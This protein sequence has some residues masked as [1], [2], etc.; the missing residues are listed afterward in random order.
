MKLAKQ[1][2]GDVIELEKNAAAK[3]WKLGHKAEVREDKIYEFQ[4]S[5]KKG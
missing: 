4:D 3:V 1:Y 5:K 2:C